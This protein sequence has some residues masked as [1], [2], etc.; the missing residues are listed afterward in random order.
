LGFNEKTRLIAS[1]GT[2][3]NLGI[4]IRALP[5]WL[6]AAASASR[7]F[8]PP[9]IIMQDFQLHNLIS[10]LK[11]LKKHVLLFHPRGG[12]IKSKRFNSLEVSRKYRTE[13]LFYFV[14]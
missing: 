7:A 10:I 2:E 4:R 6:P 13:E 9:L 11:G 5:A 14:D 3:N 1:G 8:E 12:M